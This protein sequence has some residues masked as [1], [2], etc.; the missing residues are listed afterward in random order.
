MSLIPDFYRDKINLFV[1][2]APIAR[3]NHCW[4]AI[5]LAF[6]DYKDMIMELAFEDLGM[7]NFLPPNFFMSAI[8][9]TFCSNFLFICEHFI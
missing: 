6:L 8:G 9:G 7:Y 2:L 5:V 3:V 1:A 4:S